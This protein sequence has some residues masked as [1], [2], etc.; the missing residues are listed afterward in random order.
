MAIVQKDKHVCWAETTSNKL[1]RN[2][3]GDNTLK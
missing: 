1:I 3:V 2:K